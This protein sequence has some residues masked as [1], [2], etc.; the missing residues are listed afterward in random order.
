LFEKSFGSFD[1]TRGGQTSTECG[2]QSGA[3]IAKLTKVAVETAK[4]IAVGH[5]RE[6]RGHGAMKIATYEATVENGLIRLD[7]AVR[8]PEH[9]RVYVVVPGVQEASVFHMRSPRLA[10]PG[11]AAEFIKEVSEVSQD[12]GLR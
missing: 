5:T 9:A 4:P 10:Q 2:L 3:T 7:G 8:L 1:S 12:A 6:E 11:R